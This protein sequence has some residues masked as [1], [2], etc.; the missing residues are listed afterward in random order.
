MESAAS[1]DK[2]VLQPQTYLLIVFIFRIC[3]FV[4]QV[5]SDIVQTPEMAAVVLRYKFWSLGLIS[6]EEGEAY[7]VG[8]AAQF[9]HAPLSWWQYPGM[10]LGQY[11]HYPVSHECYVYVQSINIENILY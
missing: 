11:V 3:V 4:T 5:S 10:W 7:C 2:R 6:L 9:L 8:S 1:S